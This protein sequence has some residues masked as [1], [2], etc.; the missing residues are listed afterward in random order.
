MASAVVVNPH[1]D[2]V[3][4]NS[5]ERDRERDRENFATSGRAHHHHH[6]S[7]HHHHHGTERG[8]AAAGGGLG[9]SQGKL[10]HSSSPNVV[11]VHYKVGRK[12]GEGSFG[13][14]YEGKKLF[15][16]LFFKYIF[17]LYIHSDS[18]VSGC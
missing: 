5:G 6:S 8:A 1:P 9:G 10:H 12:I 18:S 17:A 16:L 4:I 13:I 11:G 14:I 15:V 2:R 7:N 3:A